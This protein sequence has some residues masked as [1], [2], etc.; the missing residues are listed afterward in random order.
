MQ[1]LDGWMKLLLSFYLF[2]LLWG[3]CT[4]EL[5]Q[6]NSIF[7]RFIALLFIIAKKW[8]FANVNNRRTLRSGTL[9]P[10][11]CGLRSRPKNVH[12]KWKLLSVQKMI[13]EGG[14]IQGCL[15]SGWPLS[16][17]WIKDATVT[18]WAIENLL[19]CW[20]QWEGKKLDRAFKN[21]SQ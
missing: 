1:R 11:Y 3:L 7:Y 15:L 19:G 12:I 20:E 6:K 5:I 16:A 13:E 2:I 4:T 9:Y 18:T 21:V 17:I 10:L 14:L 8:H